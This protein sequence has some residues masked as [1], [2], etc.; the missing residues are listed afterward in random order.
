MHRIP[1]RLIIQHE[2]T[3]LR[4]KFIARFLYSRLHYANLI[5]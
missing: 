5:Q 3:F 4:L 1:Q 2:C